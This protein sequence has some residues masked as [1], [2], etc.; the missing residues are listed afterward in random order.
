MFPKW[1]D[2]DFEN[3]R[4]TLK[5]GNTLAEFS[6]NLGF[7]PQKWDKEY[8][9]SGIKSSVSQDVALLGVLL[10]FICQEK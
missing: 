5:T 8:P 3:P 10:L 2:A 9:A 6:S 4:S 1:M 7:V